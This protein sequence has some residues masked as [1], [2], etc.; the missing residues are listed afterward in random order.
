M[1]KDFQHDATYGE[2]L[3]AITFSDS[4]KARMKENLLSAPVAAGHR[5]HRPVSAAILAAVLSLALAITAA[6]AFFVAPILKESYQNS[7][8]YQQSS[9]TL[10]EAVNKNGWT[11]TLTDCVID[12]YN[13]YVGINLAAPDGTVLDAVRGYNFDDWDISFAGKEDIGGSSHYERVDD[14]N[15]DDNSLSFILRAT[16]SMRDVNWRSLDG[17]ELAISFSG[18]YHN[19][20]WDEVAEKFD[21]IYDCRETWNF[22]SKIALPEKTITIEPNTP[23]VTLGVEADITKIEVTP[24]GAYV[25]IEG[26]AL[27]GHHSWVPM[28]A[29]DGWYGCVEYQDVVLHLLDGTEIALKEG[30]DGS[31]CSGGTDT[32]EPGRLFLAR[33]G[34]TLLDMD[35]VDFITVCGVDISLR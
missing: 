9:V 4:V 27:K 17:K 7:A 35:T 31:G 20:E 10:N 29:P 30:M 33:R 1:N 18:L 23:V 12:E 16:Y 8:G 15:P 5:V 21:K 13:I 14:G 32:S 22:T 25:Y 34:D 28:N 6:A 11:M 2:S 19:G 24:I 3:D 26:D